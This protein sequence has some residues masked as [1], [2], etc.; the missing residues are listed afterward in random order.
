MNARIY[1][2]PKTA[3]QSGRANTHDWVLEY[4]PADRRTHD[5][6]TG[7]IGSSDTNRQVRLRFPSRE[8]A[9][10][11]AARN[12]IAVSVEAPRERRLKFKSYA[13]NFRYRA[14]SA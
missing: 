11:F 3:M 12:G 8:A 10:S 7:W 9:E 2:P 5:P 6:L 14:P 13:D 1:K 4:A